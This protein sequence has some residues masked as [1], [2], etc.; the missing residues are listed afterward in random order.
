MNNTLTVEAVLD[1]DSD[2]A[3]IAPR[4]CARDH[5]A[6]EGTGTGAGCFHATTAI[7]TQMRLVDLPL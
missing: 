4:R 5:V 7:S 6:H 1:V 2:K 3:S